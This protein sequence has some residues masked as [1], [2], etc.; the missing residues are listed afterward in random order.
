[1]SSFRRFTGTGRV[2]SQREHLGFQSPRTRQL[3][4]W[5]FSTMPSGTWALVPFSLLGM[6]HIMPF[7][8]RSCEGFVNRRV[9][10]RQRSPNQVTAEWPPPPPLSLCQCLSQAP[11]VM[12]IGLNTHLSPVDSYMHQA[13]PEPCRRHAPRLNGFNLVR[14]PSLTL[15]AREAISSA[16]GCS[17][18]LHFTS[19]AAVI[20]CFFESKQQLSAEYRLTVNL[21][22]RSRV[23]SP[24]LSME[25]RR[26]Y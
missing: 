16:C 11:N 20:F 25:I 13:Y 24:G 8:R 7:P 23:P 6:N 19:S 18:R 5:R 9:N 17:E 21:S 15:G 4:S 2:L 12:G 10:A 22:R 3:S 1:M 26:P 14:V